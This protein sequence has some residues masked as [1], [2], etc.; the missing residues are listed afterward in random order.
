MV[1]CSY[2]S[3]RK[4]VVMMREWER[5]NRMGGKS[6]DLSVHSFVYAIIVCRKRMKNKMNDWVSHHCARGDWK[7]KRRRGGGG[8]NAK[9]FQSQL[10]HIDNYA[11]RRYTAKKFQTWAF[12]IMSKFMPIAMFKMEFRQWTKNTKSLP[13]KSECAMCTFIKGIA[14]VAAAAS[15]YSYCFI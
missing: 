6:R 14:V 11:R 4:I 13:H 12:W 7:R 8:L 1:E 9:Q 2:E 3:F 15:S 5:V 10:K